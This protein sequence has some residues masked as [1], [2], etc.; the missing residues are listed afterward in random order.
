MDNLF[1]QVC[2]YSHLEVPYGAFSN[3]SHHGFTLDDLYWPTSEHYFQAQKFVGTEFAEQVRLAPGPMAA[4]RLGR[5]RSFPLRPDWT[6]VRDDVMRR[7][8]HAKFT[9]H[10]DLRT[11]LLST[12]DAELIE[13]S[14]IDWYWGC[15][16]DGTGTNRLGQLLME[17]RDR[18][19]RET[20]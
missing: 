13:N 20:P 12:G 5:K 19:R 6:E 15:G 10:P 16:K 14:P 8:L 4:A 17:L 18:L 11:L 7:A 1:N 9:Q 2:F 3:F